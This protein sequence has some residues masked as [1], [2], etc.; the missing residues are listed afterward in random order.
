[1]QSYTAFL[2]YR[3]ARGLVRYEN[4]S[5]CLHTHSTLLLSCKW[6]WF[7]I[8]HLGFTDARELQKDFREIC[9][10][11]LLK[12]ITVDVWCIV[13]SDYWEFV[14]VVASMHRI[15]RIRPNWASNWMQM[16][17]LLRGHSYSSVHLLHDPSQILIESNMDWKHEFHITAA[18]QCVRVCLSYYE[19]AAWHMKYSEIIHK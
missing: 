12:H 9:H 5:L 11:H 18:V 3:I 17:L 10:H 7:L 6:T 1:M 15:P 13:G 16:W 4:L 19:R 14:V 2:K 8:C